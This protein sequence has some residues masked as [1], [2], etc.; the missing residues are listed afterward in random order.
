M[1]KKNISHSVDWI[2]K[3]DLNNLK[4][5]N[6]ENFNNCRLNFFKDIKV[7]LSDCSVLNV[8][9]ISSYKE[10]S[11][12]FR[13]VSKWFL[14]IDFNNSLE[15]N[16]DKIVKYFDSLFVNNFDLDKVVISYE[17][18]N[19]FFIINHWNY[20]EWP[21]LYDINREII[22][23]LKNFTK[24]EDKLEKISSSDFDVLNTIIWKFFTNHS[25]L[26]WLDFSSVENFFNSLNW[27]MDDQVYWIETIINSNY[28][29]NPDNE[30]IAKLVF[31]VNYLY[32]YWL[33]L[34]YM[35]EEWIEDLWLINNNY[36]DFKWSDLKSRKDELFFKFLDLLKTDELDIK[37]F[38]CDSIDSILVFFKGNSEYL[39]NVII[40]E[41][42]QH[43]VSLYWKD[44]SNASLLLDFW[45]IL[46]NSDVNDYDYSVIKLR[47]I[48]SIL[49]TLDDSLVY[50]DEVLLFIENLT[51][52][53]D[54]DSNFLFINARLHLLMSKIYSWIYK[55]G[56]DSW[57]SKI[58]LWFFNKMSVKLLLS[59]ESLFWKGDWMDNYTKV[60]GWILNNLYNDS[61]LE[62]SLDKDKELVSLKLESARFKNLIIDIL[63]A[64]MSN[65]FDFEKV[66]WKLKLIWEDVFKNT[67]NF[68]IDNKKSSN[69]DFINKYDEL[70][71]WYFLNFDIDKKFKN[72][73][74][75]IYNNNYGLIEKMVDSLSIFMEKNNS[76][77]LNNVTWL[78]DK[79]A[80]D[81][82]IKNNIVNWT[83]IRLEFENFREAGI[84]SWD[85]NDDNS[86]IIIDIIRKN[87]EIF[88]NL[89]LDWWNYK[90]YSL[91]NNSSFILLFEWFELDFYKNEI[92]SQLKKADSDSLLSVKCSWFSWRI[93]GNYLSKFEKLEGDIDFTLEEDIKDIIN[94]KP[95]DILL[96]LQKIV[97]KDW[98][99]YKYEALTRMNWKNGDLIF[100][101]KIFKILEKFPR[102]YYKM[103]LSQIKKCFSLAKEK[104]INISI[105]ISTQQ[106]SEYWDNL[107]EDIE[108]IWKKLWED[109]F[110]NITFEILEDDYL[111]DSVFSAMKKIKDMWIKFAIDDFWSWHSS[112]ERILKFEWYVD[113]IKIDKVLIENL[114]DVYWKVNNW[115]LEVLKSIVDMTH[116]IWAK[117]ICEYVEKKEDVD[118]LSDIWVD[119]L[120]W[121]FY[122]RPTDIKKIKNF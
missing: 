99:G 30:W 36:F 81:T 6:L 117:S 70:W 76:L 39:S 32:A 41:L 7:C 102:L 24:R 33:W 1:E 72:V 44:I 31:W 106:L 84:V 25:H 11:D 113:Y 9:N 97:D 114:V 118:A 67:C 90:I 51:N 8:K 105:N 82:Y 55:A 13:L 27:V 74:D 64:I 103:T 52:T 59:Y 107:M 53:I 42:V 17:L 112:Y 16:F 29:W 80:F 15:N 69:N 65:D 73:F 92:K 66:N 12:C 71:W 60:K 86:V 35:E 88:K 18:I 78:K 26:R 22:F 109:V 40:L 56:L 46:I 19:K 68:F 63:D 77:Y 122:S 87:V 48:S 54:W 111:K 37:D 57:K 96:F 100:P 108:N 23:K 89:D 116:N 120:Q 115:N 20:V 38:D 61:V 43:L 47:L 119:Y 2:E 49:K 3:I 5:V 62:E 14:N 75:I 121:Y 95:D 93:D 45:D 50:T 83:L 21:G 98:K 94:N 104:D 79:R 110:K 58:E 10:L 101:D 28:W 34:R 91:D 4:P 85:S